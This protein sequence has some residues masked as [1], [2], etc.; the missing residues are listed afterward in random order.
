[1][2]EIYQDNS[3]II[4]L[5]NK[6]KMTQIFCICELRNFYFNSKSPLEKEEFIKLFV[7]TWIDQTIYWLLVDSNNERCLNEYGIYQE[8]YD[9]FNF[10]KFKQHG[11]G[12]LVEPIYFLTRFC[13]D[14]L[15]SEKTLILFT[16]LGYWDLGIKEFFLSLDRKD[17]VE[18]AEEEFIRD[19]SLRHRFS[20]K[21]AKK[22]KYL[23]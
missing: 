14:N 1:M 12:N 21:Q 20:E 4:N 5:L 9:K 22:L 16:K 7:G 17:I 3:R 19:L 2:I 13:E 23:W 10:P 8:Y 15:L 11:F 6:R 18:L